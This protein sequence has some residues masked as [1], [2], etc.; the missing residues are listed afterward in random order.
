IDQHIGRRIRRPLF[1]ADNDIVNPLDDLAPL[2]RRE[3][4]FRH[5]DFGNRHPG[6]PAWLMIPRYV[7]P[8]ITRCQAGRRRASN[9]ARRAFHEMMTLAV[10]SPTTPRPP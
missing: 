8:R 4:A 3:N 10:P 1:D 6:L 5:I 2:I 9:W 7:M